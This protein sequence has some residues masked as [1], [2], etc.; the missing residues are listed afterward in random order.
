MAVLFSCPSCVLYNCM[1]PLLHGDMIWIAPHKVI[2]ATTASSP[3]LDIIVFNLFSPR[4]E[5]KEAE[6]SD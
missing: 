4:R 1:V 6:N 5:E 2:Y 3:D